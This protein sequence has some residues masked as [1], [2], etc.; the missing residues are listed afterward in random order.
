M[1]LV[2]FSIRNLDKSSSIFYIFQPDR[3]GTQSV[4]VLISCVREMV[5]AAT[6]RLLK[7]LVSMVTIW[8]AK[9]EDSGALFKRHVP[10]S[11]Q[12]KI[13]K[14]WNYTPL[15]AKG[16]EAANNSECPLAY[17]ICFPPK[18]TF[19][20]FYFPSF[21]LRSCHR[22]NCS[23]PV[24]RFLQPALARSICASS[25]PLP[26]PRSGEKTHPAFSTPAL[27]GP[28]TLGCAGMSYPEP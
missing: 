10:E 5:T 27:S 15:E 16:K 1:Y 7:H 18:I 17:Y 22:L 12:A 19:F 8:Q 20:L 21:L 4:P 9:K 13:P 26:L 23:D 3:T 24:L 28:A 11:I 2:G 25:S 6:R 14:E